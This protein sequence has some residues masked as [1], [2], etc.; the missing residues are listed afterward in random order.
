MDAKWISDSEVS[1]ITPAGYGGDVMPHIEIR[2]EYSVDSE[3]LDL[4]KEILEILG[5]SREG[6]KET[7]EILK[8]WCVGP[9]SKETLEILKFWMTRAREQRNFGNFE[10]FDFA[11]KMQILE[12]LE[13]AKKFWKL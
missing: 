9:E 6:S 13:L 12:T 2:N 11:N 3:I 7:L 1:C 10:I 5:V 8:F 4:G